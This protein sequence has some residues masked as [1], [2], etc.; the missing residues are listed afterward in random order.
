M[1]MDFKKY[2]FKFAIALLTL[3]VGVS[4]FYLFKFRYD[5]CLPEQTLPC[6]VLAGNTIRL[7]QSNTKFNVPQNWLEWQSNSHN[8]FHLTRWQLYWVK[9]G[10]WEW[11]SEYAQ[12]TNAVLP[13][14]NC[15]AHLGGEGWDLNGV[16]FGDLQMRAYAGNWNLANVRERVAQQGLNQARKVGKEAQFSSDARG[17]WQRD[18]ISYNVFYGDYGGKAQ[19]DF[20]SRATNGKTVTLVFMY[21]SENTEEINQVL[22]SFVYK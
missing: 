20:Y 22:D 4:I 5:T 12:V 19:I 11:D 13:F 18:S 14:E 17:D 3:V 16:S 6:S 7:P 2:R 9:T 21:A 8:N 15:A 1:Q 10:F